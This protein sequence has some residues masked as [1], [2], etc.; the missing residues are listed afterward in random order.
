MTGD[1]RLQN[2][3]KNHYLHSSWEFWYYKRPA[4]GF[5]HANSDQTTQKTEKHENSTNGHSSQHD[6]SY[7]D[8]LKPLGKISSLE[9]FQSYHFFMKKAQEM[10]RD[11]DIFFF[12]HGEVPM[13]EESPEGGIWITKIRKDDDVDSMW[14]ALI[15]ALIGEQFGESNVIGVSL[16][17][18]TKE[19]LIQV[20]LK[21]ATDQKMK[22]IVSNKMRHFLKL[23]PEFTTLYFKE[24][25]ASMKD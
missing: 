3:H 12:R 13:W 4:R 7:K 20:W 24:H 2:L 16:S 9:E 18:R 21:D 15:L 17:L 1:A 8:Q 6:L 5:D 25:K 22:T 23:N 14:E 19:K 10:P 11:I